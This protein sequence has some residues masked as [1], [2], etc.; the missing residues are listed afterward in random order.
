MLPSL[1]RQTLISLFM[2]FKHRACDVGLLRSPLENT[3]YE[4]DFIQ[5]VV[6][7]SSKQ[8]GCCA[9]NKSTL[10]TPRRW[11]NDKKDHIGLSCF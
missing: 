4:V 1:V 5:R 9:C 3:L 2:P 11:G 8:Y 6:A 7:S 10:Y